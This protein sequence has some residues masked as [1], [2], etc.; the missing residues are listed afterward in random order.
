MLR[1]GLDLDLTDRSRQAERV[2]VVR[3]LA[4]GAAVGEAVRWHRFVPTDAG[5]PVEDARLLCHRPP[6]RGSAGTPSIM[7]LRNG[8]GCHG[9]GVRLVRATGPTGAAGRSSRSGPRRRAA[10]AWRARS[11]SVRVQMPTRRP[12]SMTGT[13]STPRRA[14]VWSTARARSSGCADRRTGDV[15]DESA[16]TA[17][18]L[19]GV[20]QSARVT[21]PMHSPSSSTTG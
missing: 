13:W 1:R 17:A 20:E 16:E 7:P 19:A 2:V 14:S 18:V 8:F 11:R 15:L 6:P 3:V 10:S 12:S 4:D 5:Q 9:G 21:T